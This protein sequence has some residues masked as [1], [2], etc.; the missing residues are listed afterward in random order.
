[1]ESS[2]KIIDLRSLLQGDGKSI[3]VPA[4][5]AARLDVAGGPLIIAGSF[6]N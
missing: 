3:Y 2:N 1:M 5:I 6:I 4:N